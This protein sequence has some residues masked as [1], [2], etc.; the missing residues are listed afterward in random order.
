M[1][2][3]RTEVGVTELMEKVY[4]VGGFGG[5]AILEYDRVTDRWQ[6]RASLP[7]PLRH[8]TAAAVGGRLYVVGGYTGGWNPV[9]TVFEYD[10]A[11]DQWRERA[12]MPTARGALAPTNCMIRPPTGGRAS[13]RCQ[14]PGTT[15]QSGWWLD[16]STPSGARFLVMIDNGRPL[17]VRGKPREAW[18]PSTQGRRPYLPDLLSGSRRPEPEQG[19]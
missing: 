1:P 9:D 11:A 4:V 8:A 12:K 19:R 14:P 5:A 2:D 6:A 3:E 16:G 7:Q 17:I 15:W 18:S 10:P 13:P